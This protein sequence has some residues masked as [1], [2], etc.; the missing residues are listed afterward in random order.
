MDHDAMAGAIGDQ[1]P[2]FAICAIDGIVFQQ[3]IAIRELHGSTRE[4]DSRGRL[5]AF[6]D[7]PRENDEE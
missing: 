1:P 2:G 4:Q 7:R 5:G 3:L 6:D